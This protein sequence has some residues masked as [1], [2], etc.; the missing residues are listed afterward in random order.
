MELFQYKNNEL[1]CED[2]KVADLAKEFG[3]PLWVYSA[4]KILHEYRA[5]QDAFEEV[6]PVVCYSVKSNSNLSILRL[7]NEAGCSFD[8]VS[9]GELYRVQHAGA[10]TTRVV[11]AGVGKTDAEIRQALGQNILMFNVESEA[12]LD[13]I[14]RIAASMNR[15]APVALRLNPDI[16][17]K[18]HA[19]TT[20]GK[21]GNK[22]G[23]DIERHNALAD[24]VLADPNL[25]LRGIHMHL[26]SPI[27]TTDPYEAAAKKALEVVTEL[28]AKGH[29]TNWVNLG[30]GF[31]LN[32]RG[33]EAPPATE[34]AKVI[35]P[36]IKEAECRLALE[37][38]RS[39]CGNAGALISEVIFTKR[40]GGKLF[41]I[42]DA[43]MNDLVRPAMYDSFHRIWPVNPKLAPPTDYEAEIE[44]CE[45][46]DVVGPICESGDYL[47]KGRYLPPLQRGDL[48][49]TFSAG[50]YGT[51]MSSNYNSRPRGAEVLV[52]GSDV[53]LIR[54][55]ESYADLIEHELFALK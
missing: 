28:R 21:K 5:I 23:M 55:R 10:D 4:N 7:L 30:G 14:S 2:V 47:A 29:Q 38:G 16:D 17:A 6:D 19:K 15:V 39:V 53:Q 11:F 42:Q 45:A 18:T 54:K 26:G 8:V 50:A 37:P 9:G 46:T 22:F 20:T 12:E 35:L 32:Y 31:G 3:T 33:T 48:L 49:C 51:V 13:A 1:Y 34:Y 44:G 40:E 41:V 24:K 25:E 52:N 36:Y 43:A 27:N